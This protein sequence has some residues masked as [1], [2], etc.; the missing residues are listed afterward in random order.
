MS[1][2][3]LALDAWLRLTEKRRLRSA[4]DVHRARARMERL[5]ARYP[6]YGWETNMGY[7]TPEHQA[8]IR[9][10]GPTRHH[11]RSFAPIAQLALF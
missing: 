3:L 4:N 8:A 5:A 10:Q 9:A 2:Q 11:R 6:G 1:W 7:G